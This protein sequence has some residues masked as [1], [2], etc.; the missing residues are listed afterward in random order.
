MQDVALPLQAYW[1]C[2]RVGCVSGSVSC[3]GTEVSIEP[4]RLYVVA[5]PIGNLGDMSSRAI[6]ALQS[7]DRIA[8][9]DTR[10]SRPLLQHFG[11]DTPTLPYHEH[12]ERQQAD[13]LVASL[14]A[15]ENVALISDAGT[16]LMSDPGFRLVRA[17]REAGI[18]VV[19]I[20][21]PSAMVAALSVVGLPTDRFAFEGFL[22]GKSAARRSRLQSLAEETRTLVFYEAGRRIEDA[23]ADM[24][25]AFGAQR[26]AAV[27]RELTKTF[28]TV[29]TASLAELKVW[30]ANDE[31]QRRGEFVVLV[32]GAAAQDGD[33][34]EADRV[35][36]VLLA[37][38]GVRQAAGLAA[39]I[40][41]RGRNQLYKRAL[42]LAGKDEP[43]P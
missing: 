6:E 20:P 15:G 27:A 40:T 7:V 23:I 33:D 42:A 32:H 22:P 13:K 29:R 30:L 8:A 4:G 3:L 31:D 39:Q 24:A 25:L 21:G 43:E 26:Q 10:H 11:I 2:G 17:A 19:P 41:G 28:E 34:A 18:V 35:L 9:E 5:T 14:L 38:L 12:N 1:A 36:R 16:P 37:E